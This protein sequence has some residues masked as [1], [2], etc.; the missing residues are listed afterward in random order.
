MW[1][2]DKGIIPTPD[3][4][5]M[6]R[7]IMYRIL[8][9]TKAAAPNSPAN[10][11]FLMDKNVV[12]ETED[13]KEALERFEKELDNYKKSVMTL[14]KMVDVDLNPTADVCDCPADCECKPSTPVDPENPTEPT[15]PGEGT[16]PTPEVTE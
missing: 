2:E 5:E 10:Y 13:S 6:R 16:D 7:K 3:V 15:N 12:W 8:L 4:S 9:Q 1:R 11:Q 14:I